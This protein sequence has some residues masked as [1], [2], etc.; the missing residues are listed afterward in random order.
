MRYGHRAVSA[1]E[2]SYPPGGPGASAAQRAARRPTADVTNPRAPKSSRYVGATPTHLRVGHGRAFRAGLI[3]FTLSSL[4]CGLAGSS[5]QL[6][7]F[8]L[9]QGVGA[10]V[11]MP[12]VVSLIQRNF[13]GAARAKALGMYSATIA[14]GAV[15]GQVAGGALVSANLFGSTWRPIFLLNV[16]IGILLLVLALHWLPTDRGEASRKL[17]PAGVATLSGC[18]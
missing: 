7:G 8:R 14:L 15:I 4:L 1:A 13:A 3:V 6:I 18:P 17:D 16:P 10:G 9:A 2:G 12:Q 11:M 5:G